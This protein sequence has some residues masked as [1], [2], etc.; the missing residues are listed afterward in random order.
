MYILPGALAPLAQYRQFIVVKFLPR[1]DA[2]G[3]LV[4]GKT[5]KHPCDHRTGRV[6]PKDSGGAHN[7]EFWTDVATA[8]TVAA[9][10]GS[11]YGVGFVIAENDPFICLDMDE[12]DDGAGGWIP[13]ALHMLTQFPGAI[14]LS[15]SGRGLHVWSF[16]TAV[17]QHRK[18]SKGTLPHKWLEL[19]SRKRFI[20]LGSSA[21]GAMQ[22]VTALLPGFVAQWFPWTGAAD[23]EEGDWTDA[24]CAEYTVLT[25]EELFIKAR[26]SVPRQ[27]AS[28]VFGNDAPMPSFA[29]LFDR[30]LDVLRKA[31]PPQ[32]PGK[33]INASDADFALAKELAYWTGK[34]CARIERLMSLSQLKRDKWDTRNHRHYFRD[35]V[36]NGVTACNAVYHRKPL[37]PIVQTGSSRLAP[38]VIQH[39]TYVGRENLAV[40]FANCVYIRDSNAILLPNGDIVDQ[41]RF[42]A[43]FA[44]YVFVMDDAGT[45]TTNKAWDAFLGNQLIRFPR[46]EGTTFEPNMPFQEVVQRGGRAWVNVYLKPDVIRTPGDVGPF[47]TLL[48]KLLPNGDDA[49]I[50]LSYLAAC[51]QYPG[52]KF[53]WAPFLQ[54]T[55]GNG[56]STIISC[57]KYALG[58]K[59]IFSVKAGMIENNFNSWLEYNVLYVADDIYSTRD[60]T[61]M[62]ESLKSMIT[63]RD[64]G[65]TLKGIDSIQK[66]ICGNFIFTDNHKD[67]MKKTDDSRRLATLYCAQQSKADRLRDGLTKQFFVYT[68]IPWLEGGGYAAVADYLHTLAI[69]PRY[70]PAGE[71]QEAP[72][73]SVTQEAIVDGRTAIEHEVSEWIELQEPGFCGDFVS[74]VM[75]KRKLESVPRFAKSGTYLKI[76]EMMGRLGFEIH[77]G[78]KDGRCVVDVQ[79]DGTRPVLYVRRDT[80]AAE[81]K[82]AVEVGQRYAQAQTAAM[83]AAIERRFSHG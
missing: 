23:D 18:K 62:M 2:Q 47:M 72:D 80:E 46:V 71:C 81:I 82:G 76:K 64:H 42:N 11:G 12:C 32:M 59:Y 52:V 35:T 74:V 79:P 1:Y 78:M 77:R 66:R 7:P 20:A 29:D 57:L 51:C 6:T 50:L 13:E 33:E 4:L 40:I 9:Q 31:F 17:P 41:S 24:P 48:K 14:E 30:N 38:Q 56:K 65:I 49:I 5:D 55:P 21:S 43:E 54:G 15:N 3:V 8:S 34:D 28:S 27:Q 26:A 67:A 73:T 63:E 69:D 45:K 53:R 39:Q 58:N 75:L 25:D 60:R 83:A 68:L 16:Y 36:L 37:V 19:Y 22:D 70:N 44:G 61:D 10:L